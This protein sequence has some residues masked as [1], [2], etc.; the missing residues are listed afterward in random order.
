MYKRREL[1]RD[2][3]D[4]VEPVPCITKV[5][6]TMEEEAHC[7]D[8]HEELDCEDACEEETT[9]EDE[10]IARRVEPEMLRLVVIDH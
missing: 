8:F 10:D 9:V 3:D 2:D 5:S 7:D 1:P 4:E 6:V